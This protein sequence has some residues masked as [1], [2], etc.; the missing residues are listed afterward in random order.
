MSED[1]AAWAWAMKTNCCETA[2]QRFVVSE[3][4]NAPWR[5]DVV[6]ALG[7]AESAVA[8]AATARR[9]TAAEV[10]FAIAAQNKTFT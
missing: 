2:P 7:V 10:A 3:R 1:F 6:S 8:G 9:R 5:A 4:R